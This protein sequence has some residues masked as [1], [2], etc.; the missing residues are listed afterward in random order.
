MSVDIRRLSD[1]QLRALLCHELGHGWVYLTGGLQ[2]E[3]AANNRM[4]V[5][6]FAVEDLP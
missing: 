5:W 4:R 3:E 1:R 2:S 6:K